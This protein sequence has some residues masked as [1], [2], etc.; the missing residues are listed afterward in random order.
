LNNHLRQ[1]GLPPAA[2]RTIDTI[3]LAKQKG[4]VVASYSLAYLAKHFQI[5]QPTSHR[6]LADVEVTREL[7][8]KLLD[9]KGS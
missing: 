7:L 2:N 4:V 3:E 6:A 1:L 9:I 8:W 5:L